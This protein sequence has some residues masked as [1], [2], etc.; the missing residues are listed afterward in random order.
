MF[1]FVPIINIWISKFLSPLLRFLHVHLKLTPNLISV[2]SFF[3]S[4]I[5]VVFILLKN[6]EL[7]LLLVFLALILDGLDGALAR[8][9][10]LESRLGEKLELIFD[11][12]NEAMLFLALTWIGLVEF[13]TA[14]LA[15]IAILL[16][17][18]L[19]DKAKFDPGCKRIMLFLGY[20]INNFEIAL[21]FIFYINLTGFVMNTLIIE[22][23]R[24]QEIDSKSASV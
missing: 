19:R 24:Q 10:K 15:I 18:S 1:K 20:I 6:V 7:A 14:I 2:F 13:K 16:M 3:T 8:Y 4:T 11:R 12:I 9:F 5:A 21:T 22:Y 17:S 23:R